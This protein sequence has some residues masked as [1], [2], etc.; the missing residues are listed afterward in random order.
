[1]NVLQVGK[2][3]NKWLVLLSARQVFPFG[4]GDEN[5]ANSKHGGKDIF[6]IVQLILES[7]RGL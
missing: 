4:M 2:N 1:M 7:F 6:I 5:I 3:V